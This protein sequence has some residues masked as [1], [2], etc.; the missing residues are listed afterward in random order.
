MAKI[1]QNDRINY[2]QNIKIYKNKIDEIKKAINLVKIEM[3]R[4]HSI[5]PVS[6]FN[7]ANMILNL[8][9][10][11]CSLNEI[12]VH[13]LDVK[14]TGFL[15]KAREQVYEALIHIEKV[16]TNY[17]N[18]PFSEYA[19]AL[20][21]I[22]N[23]TDEQKLFLIKKLGYCIDL[24]KANF[25]ENT[26]W[27]WSFIEVDGRFAVIAKNLLD[28]KRYQ[29]LDE[30]SQEGYSRR[31]EH[32]NIIQKLLYEASQGYREKFELSTKNTDD[33]NKAIEFQ[34]ALLRFSQ[35]SGNEEKILKCK[36]CIEVWSNLMEKHL[37]DIEEE[38]KKK[39]FIK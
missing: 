33:L 31:R 3:T 4:D 36:K 15:E 5:E 39:Q 23:I 21:Q 22:A 7:I 24:V 13:L 8:I 9:T 10:L 2:Q 37:A 11:H 32:F 1:T 28:L 25:G 38:K 26:K 18:V 19:E 20:D 14:N 12:S 34:K 35:I 16:V 17:I 27:K 29:R 30:P 6:R